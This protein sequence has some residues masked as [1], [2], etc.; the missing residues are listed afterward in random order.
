MTRQAIAEL[1][2]EVR[3]LMERIQQLEGQIHGASPRH[4]RLARK[5]GTATGLSQPII[6]L[7][8]TETDRQQ[9]SKFSALQLSGNQLMAFEQDGQWFYCPCGSDD[10]YDD[11]CTHCLDGLPNPLTLMLSGIVDGTGPAGTAAALNGTHQLTA[12]TADCSRSVDVSVPSDEVI[13][14]TF[15]VLNP[16]AGLYE[17]RIIFEEQQGLFEQHIVFNSDSVPPTTGGEKPDC[18]AVYN[19]MNRVTLDGSEL[20][21]HPDYAGLSVQVNESMAGGV[22]FRTAANAQLAYA[23]EA[24]PIYD[25]TQQKMWIG[26][27]NGTKHRVHALDAAAVDDDGSMIT[28]NGEIVWDY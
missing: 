1:R 19:H 26:D 10:E 2:A 3:D 18:Y 17:Y 25:T 5:A 22:V 13:R 24:E 14:I 16:S 7:T 28:D 8:G 27:N 23:I 20:G 15:D 4:V 21:I 9:S 11:A 12:P 6:F